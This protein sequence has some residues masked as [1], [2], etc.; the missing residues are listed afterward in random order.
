LNINEN[1]RPEIKDKSQK[2]PIHSTAWSGN[3]IAFSIGVWP[4]QGVE[5]NLYAAGRLGEVHYRPTNRLDKNAPRIGFRTWRSPP[6]HRGHKRE[7]CWLTGL[8][9]HCHSPRSGQLVCKYWNLGS[10]FMHVLT[11]VFLLAYCA[12]NQKSD[13]WQGA[14]GESNFKNHCPLVI[15]SV[16]A[17][18]WNA[19]RS[20]FSNPERMATC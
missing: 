20:S 1:Y 3:Q 15:S 4:R 9:G 10:P 6:N 11:S 7:Y 8:L 13:V 16:A 2:L 17:G 14:R 18:Q 12:G 5:H 19:W